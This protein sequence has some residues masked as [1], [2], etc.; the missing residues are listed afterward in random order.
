[1]QPILTVIEEE[2][3]RKLLSP[4]E[5]ESL[6]IDF[7]ETELLRTN[8][9]CTATYLQTLV[10]GGIISRNEARQTLGLNPVPGGDVLSVAYSDISQN[11]ISDK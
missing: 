10:S 3:N 9:Q 8:K 6:F 7:D 2:F 11:T 4:T 5:R 1:M